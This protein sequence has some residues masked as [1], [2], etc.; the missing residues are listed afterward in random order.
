MKKALA[1]SVNEAYAVLE[2]FN[3]VKVNYMRVSADE[4]RGLISLRTGIADP[5]CACLNGH[6][7]SKLRQTLKQIKHSP[8]RFWRQ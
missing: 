7:I 2:E 3:A 8:C 4:Q 5:I 6:G 1:S